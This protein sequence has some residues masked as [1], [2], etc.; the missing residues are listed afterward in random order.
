MLAQAL[1]FYPLPLEQLLPVSDIVIGCTGQTSIRFC[2]I[3]L[4]KDGAILASASSKNIEFAVGEFHAHCTSEQI[5]PALT[6]FTQ[7]SG[8]VFYLVNQ[9][10]PVNFRD[11][12]VLGSQLDMIYCELFLCMREVAASRV[13]PGLHRSSPHIQ[14]EVAKAG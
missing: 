4:I 3:K 8:K 7:P 2:D 6:R 12:S 1:G 10:T 9:G 11:N 14:D 5:T 13:A